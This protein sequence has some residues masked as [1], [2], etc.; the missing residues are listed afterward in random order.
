[1]MYKSNARANEGDGE[2]EQ[3]HVQQHHAYFEAAHVLV[4]GAFYAHRLRLLPPRQLT[5]ILESIHFCLFIYSFLF[6]LVN[7]LIFYS[8]NNIY[9]YCG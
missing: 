6:I 5:A 2:H 3:E 4:A 1:M 9:Y 8:V 7:C